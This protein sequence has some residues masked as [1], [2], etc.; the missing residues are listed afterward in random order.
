M[1]LRIL[2]GRKGVGKKFVKDFNF[3][4]N[5]LCGGIFFNVMFKNAIG[6]RLEGTFGTVKAYD[7]ILKKVAPSTNGRYER[8]LNFRSTIAEVALIGE[9]HPFY[10]FGNYNDDHYPPAVSPYILAGIGYFHFNP[11][12][13]LNGSYVDLQ[14]LHTE[15]QGFP[16]YPKVKDYKL[17]QINFPIGMGARYDLSPVVNIRVELLYRILQTDYLDDV[18]G[19]YIDPPYSIIQDFAH[20]C[21]LEIELT[22]DYA[23]MQARAVFAAAAYNSRLF[24]IQSWIRRIG[25]KDQAKNIYNAYLSRSTGATFL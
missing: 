10:I 22:G 7:S 19:K 5:Q 21:I 8:N 11:Q 15:G 24:C 13:V 18:S 23:D 4:N 25:G 17:N 12:T 14:P 2:G 9:F 1:L 20:Q 3:R 6:I 16:E